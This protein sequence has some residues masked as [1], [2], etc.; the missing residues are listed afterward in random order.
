MRISHHSTERAEA[1][2]AELA[3]DN[4]VTLVEFAFA[5]PIIFG[6]ILALIDLGNAFLQTS[7]ATSASADGARVAIVLPDTGSKSIKDAATPGTPANNAIK[8]AVRKRVVGQTIADSD[9]V[10][11]CSPPGGTPSTAYCASAMDRSRD[12]VVVSVQWVWKPFT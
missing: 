12:K 5:L 4:G 3:G 11:M 9:I 7:Q 2:R 8:A 6:L 10:V 1:L